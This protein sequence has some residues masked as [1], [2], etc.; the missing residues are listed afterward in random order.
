MIHKVKER[1]AFTLKVSLTW[2]VGRRRPR[3]PRCRPPPAPAVR[4]R[5]ARTGAP[6]AERR[7]SPCPVEPHKTVTPPYRSITA[8]AIGSSTCWAVISILPPCVHIKGDLLNHQVWVW[9]AVTS[10]FEN[11][12]LLTSQVGVSTCQKRPVFK[13]ACNG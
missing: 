8:F 6:S 1:R 10:R 7:P 3:A 11:L 9:L 13:T 4:R 2:S 5:P 12:P